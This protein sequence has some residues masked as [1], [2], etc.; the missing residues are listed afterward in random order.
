[1][2]TNASIKAHYEE[3]HDYTSD[4][5]EEDFAILDL[6]VRFRKSFAKYHGPDPR[7]HA[8]EIGCGDG[9]LTRKIAA[10][11]YCCYGVDYVASEEWTS[12]LRNGQFFFFIKDDYRN[13][14][15]SDCD[16]VVMKGVLEHM[17]SPEETL[18][19]I[20]E[21]FKPNQ[22]ITSSPSF[23]NP[24]GYIWMALQLLFDYEMSLADLHF[25]LPSE[26]EAWAEK[27][28]Y[29]IEYKSV[30][31]D[32]GHGERLIEDFKKRLPNV[33]KDIEA[34]IPKFMAWLE[35]TLPYHNYT[36]DSGATIVYNL[37]RT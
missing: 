13:V 36:E 34:D 28:G 31:Q 35:K 8:L 1:M 33:F 20:A 21:N 23:L 11:D 16:I 29:D 18:T 26:M 27:L 10:F 30:D 15:K 7:P 24:R 6:V 4:G 3:G 37:R 19:F 14:N 9:G 2:R 17:D 32:W 12:I 5:S 22:I 25:I